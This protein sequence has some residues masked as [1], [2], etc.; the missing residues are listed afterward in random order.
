MY[1]MYLSI[2]WPLGNQTRFR[3]ENKFKPSYNNNNARPL[4]DNNVKDA[5][6]FKFRATAS[7]HK[8]SKRLQRLPADQ[9]GAPFLLPLCE[10][11]CFDEFVYPY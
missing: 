10:D 3:L 4:P 6:T 8:F 2:G 7:Q 11:L 5:A 9:N 1:Q